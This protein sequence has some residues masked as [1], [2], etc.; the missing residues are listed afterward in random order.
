MSDLLRKHH[1]GGTACMLSCKVISIALQE[2]LLRLFSEAGYSCER[3]HIHE[4]T[5]EN[6]RKGLSMDR[7]WIQ[8][9]FVFHGHLPYTS[10]KAGMPLCPAPA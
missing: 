10:I 9:V 6:R 3:V 7:R 5:I 1:S 8:A 4:R 2:R